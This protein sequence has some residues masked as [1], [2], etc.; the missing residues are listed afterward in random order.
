M[1]YSNYRS[2]LNKRVNKVNCCCEVGPQGPIGMLGPTGPTG[3]TGWTGPTGPTGYTGPTGPTGYTGP[4]GDCGLDGNSSVWLLDS[5]VNPG[6]FD[7]SGAGPITFNAVTSIKINKTDIFGVN[8]AI[9]LADAQQGDHVTIR[10]RCVFGNY[11]IYE[12]IDSEVSS[13]SEQWFLR[14]RS[15]ATTTMTDTEYIIGYTQI[16]PTGPTGYTGPTGMT[17]PTGPIGLT[18]PTGI[19]GPTGP[20]NIKGRVPQFGFFTNGSPGATT[21]TMTSSQD[22][23]AGVGNIPVTNQILFSNGTQAAP[24]IAFQSDPGSGVYLAD[25]SNVAIVAGG[26]RKLLITNDE[27]AFGGGNTINGINVGI[28][29]GQ[30]D[31]S[32]GIQRMDQTGTSGWQ[33]GYLGN[34]ERLYFTATD[35]NVVGAAGTASYQISVPQPPLLFGS[36]SIISV[37]PVICTKVIPCGFTLPNT[38]CSFCIMG[39]TTDGS[40]SAFSYDIS[41]NWASFDCSFIQSGHGTVATDVSTNLVNSVAFTDIVTSGTGNTIHPSPNVPSNPQLFITIRIS[42]KP[43]A[44][45]NPA[46]Y[47]GWIQIKRG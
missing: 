46:I 7:L 29:G 30:W 10:E 16:G 17:G 28:R 24:V 18:G 21:T 40:G 11:G 27:G 4:T 22:V 26:K 13:S 5:S 14:F 45:I 38:D 31:I 43:P 15:G 37:Q 9:W 35:L 8:M 19:T 39:H 1:S 44:L 41:F 3:P 47:G 12:F 34:Y 6:E 32:C 20:G 2:Y 23:I 42:P 36:G 33:D 25:V